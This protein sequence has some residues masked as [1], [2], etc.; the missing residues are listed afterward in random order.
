MLLRTRI[1]LFVSLS[2]A[3]LA[4]GLALT[5]WQREKLADARFADATVIGHETVWRKIVENRLQA[6]AGSA[7]L[8]TND[9]T[10]LT[11]VENEDQGLLIPRV[12]AILAELTQQQVATR[13]DLAGRAGQMIYSSVSGLQPTPI[14]DAGQLDLVLSQRRTIRDIQQD[15]TRQYALAVAVPLEQGGRVIGAATLAVGVDAALKELSASIFADAYLVNMRGRMVHGTNLDLWKGLKANPPLRGR[16]L[17][18]LPFGDLYYS[19]AAMPV[20]DA[21]GRITA[22]L[23]TAKDDTPSHRLQATIATASVVGTILFLAAILS[24]LYWYLLRSFN[25]LDAAIAVL[26]A[27]SRGDTS[28]RLDSARTSDEIGRI[29]ETVQIFRQYAVTLDRLRD[30]QDRQRRR[31][32]RFIR[33][34]MLELADTLDEEAKKQILGDLQEI[35]TGTQGV[36][37]AAEQGPQSD[38]QLGLLAVVLKQMSTRVRDQHERLDKLVAELQDALKTKTQFI[39]LQ[40]ELEIARQMQLSILPQEFPKRDDV[41]IHG[42]MTPAQNV[43][44]DFYDFFAI[45]EDRVAVVVA[46]VSGQGVPAAFFMAVSRTLLKAM[47]LFE[48][49]PGR[50]FARVNELL[51][52]ENEQT[53][54]VTMFYGVLDTVTGIFTYANGGH[55]PPLI[56]NRMG[57]VRLVEPT[58]GLALGILEGTS[59]RERSIQLDPGDT[60][61]IYTNGVVDTFDAAGEAFSEDRLRRV[62]E[63]SGSSQRTRDLPGTILAALKEFE[64][65]RQQS[66]DITCVALRYLGSRAAANAAE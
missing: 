2:F 12:Q 31:Q 54:F 45:G 43:G 51:A 61:F 36:K 66:D 27:L 47:A 53:M 65:D 37:Q 60:L 35:E 8:L 42:Q 56:V 14:I 3:L 32:E 50:C 58:G 34:Q 26:N 20:T 10:V 38:Q 5:S 44:G 39:G 17:E 16:S 30:Q 6:L 21:A 57:H 64:G 52:A 23:V 19:V 9:L 13:I 11:A 40:Q 46:D 49:S 33:Q 29:A 4:G 59:Y 28:V 7:T 62:L 1:T 41:E 63:R 24:G 55:H 48:P 18:T 15:A 25:P 22:S